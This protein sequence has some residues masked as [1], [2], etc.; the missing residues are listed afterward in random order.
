MVERQ[1]ALVEITRLRELRDAQEIIVDQHIAS[2]DTLALMTEFRKLR[3]LRQQLA[4]AEDL[5][6]RSS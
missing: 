3:V 1:Q 6:D 4:I 5:L 2:R